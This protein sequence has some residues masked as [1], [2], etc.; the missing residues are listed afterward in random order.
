MAESLVDIFKQLSNAPY[1]FIGSGFSKRYCSNAMSWQELLEH[2]AKET[3]PQSTYPFRSYEVRL[4]KGNSLSYNQKFAAIASL[5]QKDYDDLFF[6]DVIKAEKEH[7]GINY[8]SES[9]R[10]PFRTHLASLMRNICK[11]QPLEPELEEELSDL[12]IASRHSINGIITTNFDTFIETLF[13]DYDIYCGQDDLIIT[14]ATGYAEIYKIHGDL[15]APEEMVFTSQDYEHF[16]QR[17]AY[18]VSKLISIFVENPLIIIGY[19]MRDDNILNILNSIAGCLKPATLEKIS[20]RMIFVEYDKKQDV[21]FISQW[22]PVSDHPEFVI[23]RILI[24]SFGPIFK[25]LCRVRR[26]YAPQILR[27]IRQDIYNTVLSN[28]PKDSVRV[29]SEKFLSNGQYSELQSIVGLEAA[30]V[31]HDPIELD[32][33]HEYIVLENRELDPLSIV[34]KWLPVQL[35][36]KTSE[37]PVYRFVDK[38][39]ALGRDRIPLEIQEHIRSHQCIDDFLTNSL[40]KRKKT[41]PFSTITQ[42]Q[43]SLEEIKN[44]YSKLCLLDEDE[45]NNGKLLGWLKDTFSKNP[46]LLRELKL[47]KV[48]V[49]ATDLRRL[50]RICDYLEYKDA[51]PM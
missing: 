40:K 43:Q 42:I 44:V 5:I 10:S 28:E 17:K 14:Q 20:K 16:E 24:N 1:L 50:I 51:V 9:F 27:R 22:S 33:I 13:P 49:D 30:H 12:K 3:S 26:K 35:K 29:V 39:L 8:E 45:L 38:Y 36:K 46:S 19:S 32:D 41:R 2:L 23:T 18:L 15:T 4:S 48:S 21:P 25:Q 47:K 37:Y 31:A 11:R 34:E 6:K 7:E